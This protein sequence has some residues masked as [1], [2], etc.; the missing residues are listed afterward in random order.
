MEDII[1]L[2]DG[3]VLVGCEYASPVIEVDSLPTLAQWA[4]DLYPEWPSFL[5]AIWM[6]DALAGSVNFLIP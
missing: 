6:D 5:V 3:N 2:M 1:L 4:D